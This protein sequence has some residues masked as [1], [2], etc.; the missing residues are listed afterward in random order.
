VREGLRSTIAAGLLLLLVVAA[1][2]MRL[3]NLEG[4]PIQH[5]EVYS[6]LAA[7]GF[8][9]HGQSVFD[10]TGY[11]Y[12]RAV[13]HNAMNAAALAIGGERIE[14]ARLVSVIASLLS[15]LCLYGISRCWTG[16]AA[17]LVACAILTFSLW[18]NFHAVSARMY[19]V[20][21]LCF[22]VA[23]WASLRILAAPRRT[24]W[25]AL[26][27]AAVFAAAGIHRLF[28]ASAPILVLGLGACLWGRLPVR[29]L[30]FGLTLV[31]LAIYLGQGVEGYAPPAPFERPEY[32]TWEVVAGGALTNFGLTFVQA[33]NLRAPLLSWIALLSLPYALV[34]RSRTLGLGVA[35]A[36][37]SGL[38]ITA[39]ANMHEP[40]YY[41]HLFPLFVSLSCAVVEGLILDAWS[42]RDTVRDW[43]HSGS[44][45]LEPLRRRFPWLPSVRGLAVAIGLSL[46]V[47]ALGADLAFGRRFA[48]GYNQIALFA[49][50]AMLVV[51]A[52]LYSVLVRRS[53]P[54]TLAIRVLLVIAFASQLPAWMRW[55]GPYRYPPGQ[56]ELLDRLHVLLQPGD[57]LLTT[58]HLIPFVTLG[59]KTPMGFLS[60]HYQ[61]GDFS[62]YAIDRD[63]VTGLPFIDTR[64]KLDA[65]LTGSGTTFVLADF[66][67]GLHL[68]PQLQRTIEALPLVY[69]TDPAGREGSSQQPEWS[70]DLSAFR[71]WR[72]GPGGPASSARSG[73]GSPPVLP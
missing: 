71:L 36:W 26:L 19:A 47:V 57:R 33:L 14:V 45:S 53:R 65:W 55:L 68:D 70:G 64:E 22:L 8:L 17:S 37:G 2:G 32:G 5:D 23:V 25:W 1:A 11:P 31:G 56:Q 13:L 21:Q 29:R 35:L 54:A 12:D 15:I 34:K 41:L 28:L 20:F 39:G 9:H 60:Q 44:A 59:G 63:P 72:V 42:G 6:Y 38:A 67:F 40:R 10:P 61:R 3:P 50:G 4:Q 49:L 43:L 30:A 27:C 46:I 66:K 18:E 73:T 62:P 48:P 16:R 58:E 7:L 69:R 51:L 24:G 52:A